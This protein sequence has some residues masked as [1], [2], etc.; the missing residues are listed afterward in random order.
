MT[1][2]TM[3]KAK[4]A[5][6]VSNSFVI[7]LAVIIAA[8][9]SLY[10]Y[11]TAEVTQPMHVMNKQIK[12][13]NDV[14]YVI[15]YCKYTDAPASVA[16]YIDGNVRYYLNEMQAHVA[17][18]CGKSTATVKIPSEVEPG[19][20]RLLVRNIYHV[21]PIRDISKDFISETFTVI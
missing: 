21:N 5:Y 8:F 14:V 7:L 1:C 16:R 11:K 15:E 19:T 17:K 20:Y 10:P 18:G 9:W 3:T 4:R 6:V 2:E 12:A 13:G